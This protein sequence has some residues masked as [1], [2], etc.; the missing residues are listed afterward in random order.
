MNDSIQAIRHYL[1]ANRLDRLD[2]KA[3]LI[4]MDGVLFDSMPL[5]TLAWKQLADGLGIES[6]REEFYLYEGMTG[7]A[8]VNLL[9]RRRFGSEPTIKEARRL[10]KV[11]AGYFQSMG[12]PSMMPGAHDMLSCLKREGIERVLVTGSGQ[13]D[14]LRRIDDEYQ[15]LFEQHLR[16]TAADVKHGKPHPEPYLMAQQ[17]VKALPSQTIVIE[18]APLGVEAGHASGAF[19]IAITTGPVPKQNFIDSG[20]DLIF[21]SMPQFAEQL[22]QLIHLFRTFSL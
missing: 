6:S 17:R 10:Y 13:P 7:V 15:D 14:I 11:K 19:T 20:A 16:I 1:E 3:A 12:R 4:D 22:P 5:H 8:T 2:I 21:D 18:N 9:F